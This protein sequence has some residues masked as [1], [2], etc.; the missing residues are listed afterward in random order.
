MFNTND[1][2]LF[3]NG[4]YA[5]ILVMDVLTLDILFTLS[6]RVNPDWISTMHI[7]RPG[8]SQGNNTVSDLL[9]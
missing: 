8:K 4:Y 2:R 5:E 1:V 7:L 9:F 6:S 3:C